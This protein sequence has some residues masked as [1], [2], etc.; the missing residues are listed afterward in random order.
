MSTLQGA[1]VR[2]E[3]ADRFREAAARCR[4]FVTDASRPWVLVDVAPQLGKLGPPP[5]AQSLSKELNTTV[6]AFFVQTTVSN[7]RVEHWHSGQLLREL[8]YYMDGGGWIAQSGESQE[9]EGAYF[10]AEDE[11]TGPNDE[12]PSNLGDEI[13]S[14][15]LLRYEAARLQRNAG[16]VLDLLMGGDV[17]RLCKFYGADVG[18]PGAHGTARPNWRVLASVLLIVALF[19]GAIVLGWTVR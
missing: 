17:V 3:D 2:V 5:F 13:S 16:P 1:L 11:G 9:W 15:E 8:E 10:F 18:Q 4:I 6:I 14:A 7:E 19:I 12:W